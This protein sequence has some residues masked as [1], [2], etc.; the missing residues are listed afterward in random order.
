MKNKENFI[1]G[2][3][4]YCDRWCERCPFSNQCQNFQEQSAKGD[5]DQDFEAEYF[6]DSLQE[7]LQDAV[8]MLE[9]AAEERGLDWEEIQEAAENF[10]EEEPE[11]TPTQL[12][13][14]KRSKQYYKLSSLW[15]DSNEHLISQKE[16]EIQ[17]KDDLGINVEQEV[18]ELNDALNS[19]YHYIY[20]IHTKIGR[21]IEGLHDEWMMEEY[22]IQ[23]DANGTAK[24][25]L[26]AIEKSIAAWEVIRNQM[27]DAEDDI[28]DILVLL[29]RLKGGMKKE[30]PQAEGFVRPGFDQMGG[31]ASDR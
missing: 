6:L 2:I 11:Y 25:T 8:Q 28:L 20:F 24:I 21:A 18:D 4:N 26:I 13:L 9:Q 22:P 1:P 19:I 16:E 7:S 5:H 15:L 29:S 3:Y 30:F 12:N 14:I 31:A 17:R 23:N 10:E 27:P